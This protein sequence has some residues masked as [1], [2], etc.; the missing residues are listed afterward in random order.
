MTERNRDA[1]VDEESEEERERLSMEW[2]GTTRKEFGF[3]RERR[4]PHA[5]DALK[6][7]QQISPGNAPGWYV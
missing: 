7:P 4:A 5:V 3:F 1:M 2:R 6:G